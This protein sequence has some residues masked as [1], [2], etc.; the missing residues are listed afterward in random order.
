MSFNQKHITEAENIGLTLLS[1][2]PFIRNGKPDFNYK[3][4]K[5][6]TCSHSQHLQ[7]THVRRNAVRCSICFE[8]EITKAAKARGYTV[9]GVCDNA[10]FRKVKRDICGHISEI[11]HG[12][13]K[14][15]KIERL[16]S[17]CQECYEIKLAKDAEAADMT[18]LGQAITKGGVFRHYMFNKCG[19][20]RDIQAPCISKGNFSCSEC[21]E[22][23]YAESALKAGLVYIG[24]SSNKSD[25]KRNYKL[26]CGHTKEIRMDHASSGSYLCDFCGDSH[27][28][29]PSS[30]YLL[31]ITHK[32]NFSWL[33]LGFAKD[34]ELRKSGY[35]LS[36]GCVVSTVKVVDVPTGAF[37][38]S[39]EKKWHKLLKSLRLDSKLMKNYHKSNGFTECYSLSAKS[40]ITELM[41]N[42]EKDKHE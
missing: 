1:E 6:N 29:K 27:Y 14:K 12:N 26:P 2:E 16:T 13:I 5:F 34:L 3:V 25:H 31:E 10:L 22:N 38:V 20:K 19:H 7:V 40:I 42:L 23:N 4:Y 39:T 24:K 18:Y 9:I 11:R 30:I 28:T 32:D 35:G 36:K 8:H 15:D 33:K 37:A 21:K 41:H 17:I